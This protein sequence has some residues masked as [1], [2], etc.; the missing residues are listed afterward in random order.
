M[1]PIRTRSEVIYNLSAYTRR[2]ITCKRWIVYGDTFLSGEAL[3]CIPYF[4][5]AA[6]LAYRQ[7]IPIN[8]PSMRT[9]QPQ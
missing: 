1:V 3:Q 9:H 6:I 7:G 5:I 8:C 2:N 4:S